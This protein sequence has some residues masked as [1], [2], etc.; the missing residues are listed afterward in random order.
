MTAAR[1]WERCR[2]ADAFR[3]SLLSLAPSHPT[4]SVHTRDPVAHHGRVPE[5]LLGPVIQPGGAARAGRGTSALLEV[6]SRLQAA[7]I[8]P[9]AADGPELTD[10]MQAGPSVVADPIR[11]GVVGLGRR[12][13]DAD[14]RGLRA[15]FGASRGAFPAL[16]TQPC[17]WSEAER[18][19][20]ARAL[21]RL[22]DAG[23]TAARMQAW[24]A[25]ASCSPA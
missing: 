5:A 15:S 10:G 18:R 16:T 25:G 13:R 14:R 1:A 21:T 20:F 12:G 22:P 24:M 6:C 7:A 4:P 17:E 19:A 2:S 11:R 3:L 9:A 23:D 8:A